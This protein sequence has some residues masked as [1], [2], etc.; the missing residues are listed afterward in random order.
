MQGFDPIYLL[1]IPVFLFSLSL[2]EFAHA[3]VAYRGGDMTAAYRGRLTL[4]PLAHVDPVGTLL[5][6]MIALFTG[7]PLIGWAKPVPVNDLRFRRSDWLVWVSLAG[8]LSNVLL[9][10]LAVLVMKLSFVLG[11]ETRQVD[12]LAGLL[13]LSH[14]SQARLIPQGPASLFYVFGI[15]FVQLNIVLAIFNLLP[16]PPLDGSKLLYHYAVRGNPRMHGLWI[17]LHQY[18]FLLLYFLI[19]APPL[20]NALQRAYSVPLEHIINWLGS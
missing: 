3:W 18:G 20:R 9:V 4:S 15:M 19:L 14:D 11:G 5:L 1:F 8:P 10:V 6:P 7:V 13:R 17:G 2:H 12:F 16:I